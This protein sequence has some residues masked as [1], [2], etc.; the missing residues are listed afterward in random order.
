MKDF[1]KQPKDLFEEAI[2]SKIYTYVSCIDK[3]GEETISIGGFRPAAQA[4][5]DIHNSLMKEK[6]E[7]IERLKKDK[8][9]TEVQITNI[10][11]QL[12]L[13]TNGK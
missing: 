10:I 6:E 3:N 5:T 2:I 8:F 13:L 4:V 1:D 7:E 12:K 9:T 11:K